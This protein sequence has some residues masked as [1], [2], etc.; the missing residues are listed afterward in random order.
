MAVT[1]GDALTQVAAVK[2]TDAIQ[3]LGTTSAIEYV[4]KAVY[5][6]KDGAKVCGKDDSAKFI[7]VIKAVSGMADTALGHDAPYYSGNYDIPAGEAFSYERNCMTYVLGDANIKPGDLLT[8]AANGAFT[9][10]TD[11]TLAVG[12]AHAAPTS[13][14]LVYAYIRAL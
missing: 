9:T 8:T 4:G 5:L 10:T 11:A 1:Y 7:G 2:I 12:R 6:D 13:N 3:K 14:N